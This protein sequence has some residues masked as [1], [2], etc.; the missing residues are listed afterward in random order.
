MGGYTKFDV[1]FWRSLV[2]CGEED[3]RLCFCVFMFQK[4]WGGNVYGIYSMAASRQMQYDYKQT[5]TLSQP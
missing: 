5:N 2:L 1:V 4:K 3:S